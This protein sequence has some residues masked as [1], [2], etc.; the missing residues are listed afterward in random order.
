MAAELNQGV[1]E[2][3]EGETESDNSSSNLQISK[4]QDIDLKKYFTEAE[5]EKLLIKSC[6]CFLS[7]F[8]QN[9]PILA[10]SCSY[11]SSVDQ[12]SA[13]LVVFEPIRS[14][15]I[16]WRELKVIPV[17]SNIQVLST[18]PYN[19]DFFAAGCISGDLY[20]YNYQNTFSAENQSRITEI[21]S[22]SNDQGNCQ[23]RILNWKKIL[24]KFVHA[25]S[26]EILSAT[27]MHPSL[28]ISFGLLTVHKD[29]SILLW[30]VNKQKTVLDK[31]FKIEIRGKLSD[32]SIKQVLA[33]PNSDLF[34]VGTLEG[35]LLCSLT[36]IIPIKDTKMF[37]PVIQ[38]LQE[39]KFEVTS[40]NYSNYQ[41]KMYVISGGSDGEVF[42]HEI[43]DMMVRIII[44]IKS[45][46]IL[47]FWF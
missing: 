34:V 33:I 17:K 25:F 18:C 36:Q 28:G 2:V 46:L 40:L 19:K 22:Q 9:A 45:D 16:F 13:F 12:K 29:N 37:N 21:F 8:I 32:V 23:I 43:E 14:T 6:A 26:G 24:K 47:N 30:K 7:T 27:W 41:G 38:E 10:V 3:F 1:T 15:Q 42:I 35:L 11:Q 39:H 44:Q 4:Y 20:I 31:I 5:Q